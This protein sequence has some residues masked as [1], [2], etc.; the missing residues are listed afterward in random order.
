MRKLLE[1]SDLLELDR[2]LLDYS[3]GV[4]EKCGDV[5]EL[6]HVELVLGTVTL[7]LHETDSTTEFLCHG[8]LC[9]TTRATVRGR[10][11]FPAM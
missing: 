10:P 7:T 1:F 11:E 2:V 6:A 3:D 5:A 9:C 8:S 4:L